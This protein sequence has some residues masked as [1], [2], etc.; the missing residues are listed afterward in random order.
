MRESRF[1]KKPTKSER[2]QWCQRRRLEDHGVSG[3]ERWSYLVGYK[4]QGIVEWSDGDDHSAW[5][6]QG[7]T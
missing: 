7:H 3:G 1:E 2:A 4:K 5:N 6:P